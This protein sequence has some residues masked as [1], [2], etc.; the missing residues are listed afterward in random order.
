MQ[1]TRKHYC[2]SCGHPVTDV[3]TWLRSGRKAS[4]CECSGGIVNHKG[5]YA[6]CLARF[7][8]PLEQFPRNL[9]DGVQFASYPTDTGQTDLADSLPFSEHPDTLGTSPRSSAGYSIEVLDTDNADEIRVR[10]AVRD[11]GFLARRRDIE[12]AASV[13]MDLGEFVTGIVEPELD[14]LAVEGA[15]LPGLLTCW[16][17]DI[18]TQRPLDVSGMRAWRKAT[19]RTGGISERVTVKGK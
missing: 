16:Q 9:D 12:Y 2:P 17:C 14:H 19:H 15:E 7:Q 10:Q 3:T 11:F 5:Q 6:G 4:I 18:P 1:A 13:G 8:P